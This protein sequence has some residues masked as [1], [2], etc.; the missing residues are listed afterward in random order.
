MA[1]VTYLEQLK[2]LDDRETTTL[3]VWNTTLNLRAMSALQVMEARDRIGDGD[4][5]STLNQATILLKHSLVTDEGDVVFRSESE[6]KSVL[7]NKSASSLGTLIQAITDLNGLN[8]DSAEDVEEE[9]GN[10]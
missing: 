4:D 7:R 10:E 9:A 1:K 2:A 8:Q 5:V 3:D 6:V